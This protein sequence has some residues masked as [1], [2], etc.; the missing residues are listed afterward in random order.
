MK[1][2]IFAAALLGAVS[3]YGEKIAVVDV[4][5]CVEQSKLGKQEQS[6]FDALKKQMEE[7]MV[8]KE[9]E[10]SDLAEKLNDPDFLDSIPA[11]AETELKRKFRALSQ[12][13]GQ[14]QN[15]FYQALNQSN[16]KVMQTIGMAISEA[17]K[18]IA[19]R[20]GVDFIFN[21]EACFYAREKFDLS[22]TIITE[23]DKQ[24]ESRMSEQ[25]LEAKKNLLK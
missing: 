25:S 19:E 21:D 8:K 13:V 14:M 4:K 7:V 20:D 16:F 10:L 6:S 23:M 15:Q 9:K 5:L 17:S 24:Y 12:E 3:L 1:K 18:I 2:W 11:E 22:Q